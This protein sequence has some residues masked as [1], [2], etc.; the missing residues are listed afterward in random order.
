MSGKASKKLT[1]RKSKHKYIHVRL[2]ETDDSST[3]S[4]G[5]S[6]DSSYTSDDAG[7]LIDDFADPEW[8]APR[9]RERR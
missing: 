7:H 3:D 1:S 2:S 5:D 4:E 9:P 6:S 8:E